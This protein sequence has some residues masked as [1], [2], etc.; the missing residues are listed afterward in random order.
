MLLQGMQLVETLAHFSRERIPDRMVH[1][2]VV[3]AIG[4]FEV[5]HHGSQFISTAFL[6]TW[7]KTSKVLLR[8]LTVGPG[9]GSADT[10]GDVRAWGMKVFTE[11][12]N[13]DFVFNSIVLPIYVPE[14][15]A[16]RT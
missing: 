4:E 7:G 12:G 11:G 14:Q 16:S 15:L 10:L 3:G 13:Q 6:S 1:G 5:T 9:A 2:H 8:V